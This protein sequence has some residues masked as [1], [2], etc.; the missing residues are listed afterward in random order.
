[1][2]RYVFTTRVLAC[3]ELRQRTASPYMLPH[4][5]GLHILLSTSTQARTRGDF[6]RHCCGGGYVSVALALPFIHGLPAIL[7]LRTYALMGCNRRVLIVFGAQY[8][9]CHVSPAS[10]PKSILF[11]GHRLHNHRRSFVISQEPQM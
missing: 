4:P 8:V 9:V 1:M 7:V 5:V 10:V 11:K 6:L 3:I 2:S